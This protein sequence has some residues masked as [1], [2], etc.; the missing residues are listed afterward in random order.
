MAVLKAKR[1]Y[2]NRDLIDRLEVK[3]LRNPEELSEDNSTIH[4]LQ[5]SGGQVNHFYSIR[6]IEAG[7]KD[8][9]TYYYLI[10]HT[11]PIYLKNEYTKHS[12][13]SFDISITRVKSDYSLEKDSYSSSFSF[14]SINLRRVIEYTTRKVPTDSYSSSFSFSNINL[15]DFIRYTTRERDDNYS[16]EFTFESMS[17]VEY[18]FL[19]KT[20][21]ERSNQ[22]ITEF[23]IKIGE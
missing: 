8:N 13:G 21:V 20:T 2:E 9:A 16:S 3:P 14:N 19:D 12:L 22:T 17:M 18:P 7:F 6:D 11:Y 4:Y 5:R 10:S 15:I 23:K 1:R